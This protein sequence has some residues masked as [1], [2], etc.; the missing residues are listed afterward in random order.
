[1][2]DTTYSSTVATSAYPLVTQTFPTSRAYADTVSY[3]SNAPAPSSELLSSRYATHRT[4]VPAGQAQAVLSTAVYA[5]ESIA[6]ILSGLTDAAR[7]A[8]SSKTETA[9]GVM[10]GYGTRVSVGNIQAGINETLKGIDSLVKQTAYGSANILSSTSGDITFQTSSYGGKIQVT[11][12][13]FDVAGLGLSNLDLHTAEGRKSA[14]ARLESAAMV[15]EKRLITLRGLQSGM[16]NPSAL[17]GNAQTQSAFAV[18]LKGAL[19]DLSA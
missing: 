8:D 5:A 17:A 3:A 13:P 19:V 1:M 4:T 14:I 2:A 7:L 6:T 11:P 10:V 18:S 12:Q 16:S 15:A 9:A